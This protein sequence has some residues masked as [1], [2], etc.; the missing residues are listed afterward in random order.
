M[1]FMMSQS[2]F[3]PFGEPVPVNEPSRGPVRTTRLLKWVGIG[4][5]WTLVAAIVVA[6]AAL[7]EPGSF[8]FDR[9]VALLQA[10]L[11][12]SAA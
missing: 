3:D 1:E 9:A 10:L 4:S 8:S 11:Q 7:F 6:R 2:A 5:F 12:G